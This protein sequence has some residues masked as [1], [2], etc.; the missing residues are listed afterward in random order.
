MTKKRLEELGWTRFSS[1]KE[2]IEEYTFPHWIGEEMT[3]NDMAEELGVSY[4]YLDK[5]WKERYDETYKQSMKKYEKKKI[6]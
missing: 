1:V 2:C 6:V 3:L 5:L 4:E